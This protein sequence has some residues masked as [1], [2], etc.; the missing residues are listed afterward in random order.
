M[1]TI[2]ADIDFIE[3]FSCV[4]IPELRVRIT[5]YYL[6]DGA[7][8]RVT[9]NAF[10]ILTENHAAR[11][12]CAAMLAQS[13]GPHLDQWRERATARSLL[14]RLSRVTE[15]DLLGVRP[16]VHHPDFSVDTRFRYFGPNPIGPVLTIRNDFF[17][18]LRV[19]DN[20]MIEV[21]FRR[22]SDSELRK[23][24]NIR[25]DLIEVTADHRTLVRR[26][27]VTDTGDAK[28]IYAFLD[29]TL[30]EALVKTQPV[31]EGDALQA[32][33]LDCPN[34]SGKFWMECRLPGAVESDAFKTVFETLVNRLLEHVH[35]QLADELLLPAD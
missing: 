12:Y 23:P 3:R 35:R 20:E 17:V 14:P 22:R 11:D 21:N 31:R 1:I 30:R 8:V 15:I 27:I 9:Q 16:V 29:Q 4:G 13:T 7:R 18:D 28:Y 6:R 32:A 5:G 33:R 19:V 24:R 25:P 34:V 2:P 26:G 10:A